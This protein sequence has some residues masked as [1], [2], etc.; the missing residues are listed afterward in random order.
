VVSY[1]RVAHHL[2]VSP[3]DLKK[4]MVALPAAPAAFPTT[5]PSCVEV[6]PVPVCLWRYR[7][8]RSSLNGPIGR[9]FACGAQRRPPRWPR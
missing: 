1:S 4:H 7:G 6:P 3:S 2:R 8:W 9:A 5:P